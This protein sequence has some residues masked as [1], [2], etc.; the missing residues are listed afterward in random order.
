MIELPGDP[1]YP[2]PVRLVS[3]L[4]RSL[5]ELVPTNLGHTHLVRRMDPL[6]LVATEQALIDKTWLA[7]S[8]NQKEYELTMRDVYVRFAEFAQLMPAS[9]SDHHS[10]HGGLF[11]HSVDVAFWATRLA[12]NKVFAMDREPRVRKQLEFRWR[13]ATALAGLLHD[14][15]KA[16]VDIKVTSPDGSKRWSGF[17]RPLLHWLDEENLTYYRFEFHRGRRLFDHVQYATSAVHYILGPKVLEFLGEHNDDEIPRAMMAAIQGVADDQNPIAHCVKWADKQSSMLDLARMQ[18][19]MAAAGRGGER[20]L[21]PS[22][23]RVWRQAIERGDWVFNQKGPAYCTKKGLLL[24]YPQALT[25]AIGVLQHEGKVKGAREPGN[26][27]RMLE[28]CGVLMPSPI[29]DMDETLFMAMPITGTI[30]AM[31]RFMRLA[32]ADQVFAGMRVPTPCEVQF[33][34]SGKPVQADDGE[35]SEKTKPTKTRKGAAAK[36]E[37][38]ADGQLEMFGGEPPT[39]PSAASTPVPPAGEIPAESEPEIEVVDRR[40]RTTQAS[41]RRRSLKE[42]QQDVAAPF[43]KTAAEARAWLDD[44]G[45][46]G[47]T[48]LAVMARIGKSA[49]WGVDLDVLDGHV[50]LRYPSLLEDLVGLDPAEIL[51]AFKAE[52]WLDP[53][54]EVPG[55]TT[56]RL[57]IGGTEGTAVQLTETASLLF[58][59]LVPKGSTM[60]KMEVQ[61]EALKRHRQAAPKAHQQST[62]PPQ[63][64]SAEVSDVLEEVAEELH[65]PSLDEPPPA[66]PAAPV[67]STPAASPPVVASEPP[68]ETPAP[69][70]AVVAAN[71]LAPPARAKPASSLKGRARALKQ[72]VWAATIERYGG[73]AAAPTGV[74]LHQWLRTVVGDEVPY[75][76]VARVLAQKPNPVLIGNMKIIATD[77][78]AAISIGFDPA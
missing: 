8:L 20:S 54:P 40:D 18:D 68:A 35:V 29:G 57:T 25:Y 70:P 72:Q 37:P 4:E 75:E 47:A 50:V 34:E 76:D 33:E 5:G 71:A 39:P 63:P 13:I 56:H 77:P 9:E 62:S 32:D 28:S 51:D 26:I 42:A 31:N 14:V 78:Q 36:A 58:T 3:P 43:P 65:D 53:N 73:A 2:A 69:A 41:E 59:L 24:A 17:A 52:G 10:G 23:V 1:R 21:A 48:L 27:I 6:T 74:A 19:E 55:R 61:E 16:I 60:P 22:I 46:A 11:R 45:I 38:K 66:A 15:G 7:A 30:N 67:G 44:K 12:E 64:S 49:R